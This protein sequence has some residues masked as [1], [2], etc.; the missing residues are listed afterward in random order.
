M[1]EESKGAAPPTT[2]L[3]LW[4]PWALAVLAGAVALSSVWLR[5]ITLAAVYESGRLPLVDCFHATAVAFEHRRDHDPAQGG[6]QQLFAILITALGGTTIM[7]LILGQPCGWLCDNTTIVPYVAAW[8][9]FCHA[10]ADLV[11]RAF[12]ASSAL[13]IAMGVLD[14]VSKE[15]GSPHPAGQTLIVTLTLTS[16]RRARRRLVGCCPHQVGLLQRN[17]CR[18]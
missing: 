7:N 9:A 6:L 12:T 13:R 5:R 2:R 17:Q 1:H 10:P 16:T 14:D 4:A 15:E 8:L 3:A 11:Y 18:P